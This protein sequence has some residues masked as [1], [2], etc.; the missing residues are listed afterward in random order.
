MVELE[1]SLINMMFESRPRS[2]AMKYGLSLGSLYLRDKITENSTFPCL[3]SPQA[4]VSSLQLNNN[5][6]W[7]TCFCCY[8]LTS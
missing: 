2:S 6:L 3:I 5:G 1:C 8:M 7:G 4:R